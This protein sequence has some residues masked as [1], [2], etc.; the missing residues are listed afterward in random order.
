MFIYVYPPS[1][2]AV[3]FPPGS[4]TAA[5]QALILAELQ[6]INSNQYLPLRSSGSILFASDNVDDSAW[7]ELKD[8]VGGTA[9]K[10]VQI[11]MSSGEPLYIGFGAV[12]SEVS[13]GYIFPG[14][15]DFVDLEIPA[16]TRVSVKAVNAVT[17]SE[18]SLLVNFMG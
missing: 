18:G 6:S 11:F 14:G 8:D 4:A 15:N 1:S 16:N 7:V 12:A 13:Q 17:V 2:V 3:S 9:I 10:K 5:N